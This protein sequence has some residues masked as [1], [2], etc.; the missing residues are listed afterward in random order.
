MEHL[1]VKNVAFE[2]LSTSIQ[3]LNESRAI[4]Y[5]DTCV[6]WHLSPDHDF[7]VEEVELLMEG[8]G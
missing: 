3:K 7:D 2:M 5:C 6:G 1:Y 8:P 4:Y